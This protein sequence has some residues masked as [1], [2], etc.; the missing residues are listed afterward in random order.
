MA[1]RF[2]FCPIYS[3]YQAGAINLPNIIENFGVEAILDQ[4]FADLGKAWPLTK[5]G[6]NPWS[7]TVSQIELPQPGKVKD[8]P[9][10][11]C[12]HRRLLSFSRKRTW[13]AASQSSQVRLRLGF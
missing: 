1:S 8:G 7:E 12:R 4:L 11:S 3:E 9:R 10:L 2:C 6:V 13:V 5:F